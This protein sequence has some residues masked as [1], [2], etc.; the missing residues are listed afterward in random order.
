MESAQAATLCDAHQRWRRTIV[1]SLGRPATHSRGLLRAPGTSEGA[2]KA[3]TVRLLRHAMGDIDGHGGPRGSRRRRWGRMAATTLNQPF[4]QRRQRGISMRQTRRGGT[5]P[6]GS[7]SAGGGEGFG[8]RH[9]R[10]IPIR[11]QDSPSSA[12]SA[13]RLRPWRRAVLAKRKRQDVTPLLQR[14]RHRANWVALSAASRTQSS[15]L[16][17]RAALR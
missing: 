9:V 4:P 1:A 6:A 12:R 14:L 2:T 7:V 3:L 11:R 17:S 16:R 5:L 15:L 8:A 13:R 10:E